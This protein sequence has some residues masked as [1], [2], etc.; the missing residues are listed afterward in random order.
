MRR[1]RIYATSWKE[2]ASSCINGLL[3]CVALDTAHG[4]F[5]QTK[6]GANPVTQIVESLRGQNFDEA[7]R[8]CDAALKQEPQDKRIWTLRGMAYA[9][10]ETPLS[11]LAAYQHAIYLDPDY[12]P[13]LEGAAQIEYQQGNAAAAKPLIFRVL[14]QRPNDPTSHTMLGFL[15][16]AAKDCSD[17]IPHFEKGG[18]V[19]ARQPLALAAYGACLGLSGQYEQAIPIFQQ[20]LSAE[21]SIPSVRFNLALAQWKANRPQDALATLQPAIE[22]SK[23]QDDSMLLAADIYESIND[24]QHAVDLLRKAIL[25]DPKNV[26]AYVDFAYLSYDH[27][28]MQVGI[29]ILN[30]GMTQLPN[31]A[32]LY[33]ARGI[34]YTQL[35]KFD[36]AAEDF[37]VANRLDSKLSVLGAAEGLIASQQHKSSEALSAFRSAAKAQPTDALTQYLLAEALSQQSPPEGSPDYVEEVSAAKLA[38]QLDPSMVAAHD[39]LATVYLQAGHTDLALE[40]SRA[41]LKL[42]PGDQQALYHSILALRR[43]GDKDQMASLLKQLA[44]ARTATQAALAQSKRFRLQEVPV[45]AASH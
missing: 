27:A 8:E 21:P 12:L 39:L 4:V 28:S 43:T 42:D 32:R 6:P 11:A 15:D 33:L 30:A 16:Y 7:L 2:I 13:A 5:A 34:L 41:A 20:A 22:D 19:L 24:T 36:E 35:G 44:A 23:G 1:L 3:M 45:A 9:G 31:E 10:K 38:Y 25:A 26:E 40:Q 14:L 17:A 37:G 18:D 29:D